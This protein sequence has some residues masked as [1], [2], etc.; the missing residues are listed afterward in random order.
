M[1]VS[2]STKSPTR[3]ALPTSSSRWRTPKRDV[4][5]GDSPT[6]HFLAIGTPRLIAPGTVGVC[7][8]ID[9]LTSPGIAIPLLGD[10]TVRRK[11]LFGRRLSSHRKA[12]RWLACTRKTLLLL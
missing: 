10:A 1:G 2:S 8:V 7:G 9:E 4:S 11:R 6:G 12:R 5:T 3:R